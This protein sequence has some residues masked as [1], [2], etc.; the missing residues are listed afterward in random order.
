MTAWVVDILS[1]PLFFKGF[2]A[3]CMLFLCPLLWYNVSQLQKG[4]VPMKATDTASCPWLLELFSWRQGKG[5][6]M[7]CSTAYPTGAEHFFFA[8]ACTGRTEF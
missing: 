8:L 7:R 5:M 4:I 2:I 6:E 3:L 1:F